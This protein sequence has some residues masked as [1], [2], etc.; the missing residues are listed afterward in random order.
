MLFIYSFVYKVF[1][2][3]KKELEK[4]FN[5]LTF[6]RTSKRVVFYIVLSGKG[7]VLTIFSML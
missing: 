4:G 7:L 5:Y 2:L 1:S 6:L 3:I